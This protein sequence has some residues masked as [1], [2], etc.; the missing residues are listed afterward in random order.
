MVAIVTRS[1]GAAAVV[2]LLEIN[3]V[4]IDPQQAGTGFSPLEAYAPNSF[5]VRECWA[6][7]QPGI[8]VTIRGVFSIAI[9]AGETV[10]IAL[11]VRGRWIA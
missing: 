8:D 5:G 10:T 11:D 3:S 9:P 2:P 4:G 6:P 7:A 1:A